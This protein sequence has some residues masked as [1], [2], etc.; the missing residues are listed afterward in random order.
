MRRILPGTA[1]AKADFTRYAQHAGRSLT[2]F[3]CIESLSGC[4]HADSSVIRRYP[5]Q[6]SVTLALYKGGIYIVC[7]KIQ[8]DRPMKH[9]C[10]G[11]FGPVGESRPTRQ[12]KLLYDFGKWGV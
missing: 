3:I 11:L 10:H 4:S 5:T 1:V 12:L 6:G 7:L 2:R 8:Q 9:A